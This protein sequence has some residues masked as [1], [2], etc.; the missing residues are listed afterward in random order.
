MDIELT[1]IVPADRQVIID[2]FNYYVEHG[3]AE[4]GRFR[5]VRSQIA[6]RGSPLRSVAPLR[7][8]ASGRND[9][10]AS[11]SLGRN[12]NERLSIY[13]V[14]KCNRYEMLAS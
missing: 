5:Q 11:F 12:D 4:V 2:L 13:E 1:P 6:L 14:L 7:P 8:L 3:F 10:E 9:G